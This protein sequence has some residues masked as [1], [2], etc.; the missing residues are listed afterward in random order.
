M[1]RIDYYRAL[2]GALF[3]HNSKVLKDTYT[4]R[5]SSYVSGPIGCASLLF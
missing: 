5:D 4:S 3:F 1:V 2:K